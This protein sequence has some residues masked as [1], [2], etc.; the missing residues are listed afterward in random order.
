MNEN[1][2]QHLPV[3]KKRRPIGIIS[4]RAPKEAQPSKATTLDIYK[5]YHLVDKVKINST[6]SRNLFTT[7]NLWSMISQPSE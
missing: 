3:V 1:Q 5:L 6:I 4:D 2:I 7:F